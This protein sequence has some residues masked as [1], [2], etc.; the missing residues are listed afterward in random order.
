V[1]LDSYHSNHQA[2]TPTKG[3]AF[4]LMK[5]ILSHL[6]RSAIDIYQIFYASLTAPLWA[7]QLRGQII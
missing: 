1:F 3:A 4:C 6:H 7:A 2:Y 5:G